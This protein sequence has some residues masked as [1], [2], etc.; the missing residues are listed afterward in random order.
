MKTRN[1]I[2]IIVGSVTLLLGG[3]F[4]GH[5]LYS[6]NYKINVPDKIT[7]DKPTKTLTTKGRGI[8]DTDGNKVVLNGINYGNWL[9]QEEWMSVNSI[10]PTRDEQG[11][12]SIKDGV[13]NSYLEM[14]QEDLDLA[15]ENNPNLTKDQV[16]ELQ[17]LYLDS[18]CTEEDFKNI[19]D[20]GFNMIRLPFYYRNLLEGDNDNLTMKED[21]FKY[22]DF[23]LE[24]CKKYDL[25]CILDLHGVPGGQNGLEHSGTF[26]CEFFTNDKYIDV[27]CNLWKDIALHYINDRPD[28]SYTI[29]AFDI[30]NEPTGSNHKTGKE[31]WV[32]FDKIY[33]AIRSVDQDHIISIESC[34][35][36]Y[37][38]A[39]P[40]KMGWENVLYQLHLY[41]WDDPKVSYNAFFYYKNASRYFNDYNVPLYIG[42]FTFFN[43]KKAWEKYLNYWTD[44]SI[45]WSV[46][47]YKV[48]TNGWWDSTWGL[49]VRRLHLYDGNYK[50]DCSSATYE[51]IKWNYENEV[52]SKTY[53]TGDL[54]KYMTNYFNNR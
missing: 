6:E 13:V 12:L 46:W 43:T 5:Y 8:Y 47:S 52:T 50:L 39:N 32:V 54:Y 37:G 28:L 21:A 9:I 22:L 17:E 36:Y 45:S 18:Y 15:F 20:V 29:A 33:D 19:K 41:N 40:K 35:S 23:F 3:V 11:N 2:I 48:C 7:L 14:A 38:F 27:V 30:L 51:D 53:E 1:K 31:E 49:Y 44:N 16:K 10:G 34:W 25:F 4:G 26:D 24:N 42:E